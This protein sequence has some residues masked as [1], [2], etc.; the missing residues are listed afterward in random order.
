VQMELAAP[1]RAAHDLQSRPPALDALKTKLKSINEVLWE[2][3]DKISA[4]EAAKSFDQQFVG[5]AGLVYFN[6]DERARIKREINKLLNFRRGEAVHS[7]HA[8]TT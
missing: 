3:E 8:V 4:K 6:N 1:R 5:L 7:L 2:I